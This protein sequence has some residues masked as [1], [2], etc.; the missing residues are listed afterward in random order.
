MHEA[1][2]ADEM[3]LANLLELYIHDLSAVFTQVRLGE[4]GRF[5]Y[6]SLAAYLEGEPGRRA[7]VL[8]VDGRVAGFALARRGSPAVPEPE[9]W[10]VAEFFVLRAYRGG[11]VGRAAALALWERLGGAWTVR[12]ANKNVP[13]LAFWRRVVAS[14]AGA[15]RELSWSPG[16][17]P[18]T[19]FYLQPN[20]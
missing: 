2:A 15:V 7:F 20:A 9:V 18:W 11:G 14:Y 6:A 13:A 19:V 8:R 4:D 16:T 12:V 1:G 3:L 5:G 17:E 10:D